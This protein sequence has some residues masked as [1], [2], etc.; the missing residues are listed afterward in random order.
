MWF[1]RK[2]FS[3]QNDL[4][5]IVQEVADIPEWR[6][7]INW[8]QKRRSG[9]DNESIQLYIEPFEFSVNHGS[10][11]ANRLDYW[12]IF[13]I[14]VWVDIESIDS[15]INPI[16]YEMIAKW[17][18]FLAHYNR[19]FQVQVIDQIIQTDASPS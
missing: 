5:W 7:L 13:T 10:D 3:Y 12:G 18:I 1:H 19:N 17:Y 6:V 15:P 14:L 11:L 16:L 4:S 8:T 2:V 9:K